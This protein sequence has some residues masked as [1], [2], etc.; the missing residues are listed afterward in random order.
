MV[1][2]EITNQAKKLREQINYHNYRYYVLDQPE[3]SDAEYDKLMRMLIELEQKYPDIITEDSPTQRV[4]G[5]PLKEF[6]PVVHSVP[7]LSLANAFSEKELLDFDR[8]VRQALNEDIEYVVELKMDGLS[9]ALTY[10]DGKLVRGATRGDGRTGEDITSNIKT[11]KSIPLVLNEKVD[12]EVRG[13]VFMSKG[14]FQVLNK[15]RQDKEEPLFANTRNAAAGSLRQLDPSITAAR[16]LD[17][18]IF[19]VQRI[20]GVEFDTHYQSL[21]YMRRL[22][23]KINSHNTLCSSINEAIDLCDYWSEK[24]SELPYEID[25]IVIKTNSLKQREMLGNTSKA[26]RWAIAY[27]FPAEQKQT[28]IKDIIVQVGR[29]GVLTPTAVFEPVRLAGSVVQRATLHNEDYINSKDIR[30]GDTAIIQKAGDVIPEVVKIIE[31]KRTGQEKKFSMP[32]QCPV[33]GADTF[34]SEGEAATKCTGVDCPA[35]LK[36][37]VIHFAS[38]DAM[39]IEGM[40]PAIVNQL[41]DD[42]IISS[43]A[44]LYYLKFEDLISLERMAE[45]SVNNLLNSIENSKDRELNN[46]I[47]ALG[48]PFIGARAAYVIAKEFGSMQELEGADYDRLISINEVGEKMAKSII[49]FFKQTQ[50]REFV[51]KLKYAGVNMEFKDTNEAIDKNLEGNIFVLTGTLKNYKRNQIKDIIERLG[52]RVSGSVSSRTDYVLA[53]EN[54][55]SKLE[56]ARNIIA[57]S[58]NPKLK[59]INEQ[60]FENMIK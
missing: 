50:N 9:V 12:I 51:D 22:G 34:R 53:G 26:P 52:G 38:R 42:K 4:G 14:D 35:R 39:D 37:S 43:A 13:E 49:T 41:V 8:R 21:E 30:I 27:K 24:R 25:G 18:F 28:V 29:T 20:Q 60:E 44:D 31:N 11:I 40:G 23:F 36:R 58:G 56:K 5:Q 3:I 55:G 48:I 45:K 19:N 16:P 57:Q 47:F 6:K 1:S 46:I 7:L 10:Q 17:I 2:Q 54:P 59:I 32:S 15:L 33:C